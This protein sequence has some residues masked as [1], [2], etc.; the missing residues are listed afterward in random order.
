MARTANTRPRA[1]LCPDKKRVCLRTAG[2]SE[3]S[4][5]RSNYILKIQNGMKRIIEYCTRSKIGIFL[6]GE[7]RKSILLTSFNLPHCSF[8]YFKVI[9]F[10]PVPVSPQRVALVRFS[11]VA[12][13]GCPWPWDSLR[14]GE[15]EQRHPGLLQH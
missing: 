8:L 6:L 13:Y 10:S 2:L 5:S 7:S 9:T 11:F 3:F 12:R 4:V 1:T 14:R 15:G